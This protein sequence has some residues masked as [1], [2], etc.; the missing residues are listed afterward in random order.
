MPVFYQTLNSVSYAFLQDVQKRLL[1]L[2]ATGK[3]EGQTP[4][5]I[6][7]TRPLKGAQHY[8][9]C[10]QI[11]AAILIVA[12]GY[13][14]K[15]VADGDKVFIALV[16]GGNEIGDEAEEEKDDAQVVKKGHIPSGYAHADP[17]KNGDRLIHRG[18]G[19]IPQ[20]G[21]DQTEKKKQYP[22]GNGVFTHWV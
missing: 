6:E 17:G 7:T 1:F 8:A 11:K 2:S 18:A 10:I 3:A 4:E 16:I 19:D 22:G 12:M 14:E 20:K 13:F 15:P 9:L 5:G 21:G